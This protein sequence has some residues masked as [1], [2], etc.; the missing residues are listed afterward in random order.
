MTSERDPTKIDWT[1]AGA[2]Y[3]IESTG[4]FTTVEQAQVHVRSGGA[5][6]VLISAPSKDA[7]TFVYGVNHL[8]YSI[9]N[10]PTVIS[11][12]SC[13]TNCLA[14]IAKVLNSEFGIV[15]GLMTTVHASTR[16]QHVLDGYSKR[17]RRAGES[18]FCKKVPR[19]AANPCFQIGRAVLGNVIPTTTGAAKAVSSV[20]PEL[21]GKLTG[22]SLRVPT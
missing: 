13:T 1:L 10:T 20:L 12:A 18:S 19:L 3:V 6:R 9:S 5:S 2:D 4:K 11:C 16:S 8:D 15:Q 7:P 22:L 17:D 14:P 21:A